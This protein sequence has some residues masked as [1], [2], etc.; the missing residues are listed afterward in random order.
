MCLW[1]DSDNKHRYPRASKLVPLAI[2]HIY[3][4]IRLYGL[5]LIREKERIY[6]KEMK[7]VL[8][9]GLLERDLFLALMNENNPKNIRSIIEVVFT[10][11]EKKRRKELLYKRFKFVH[12]FF[13]TNLEIKD[14]YAKGHNLIDYTVLFVLYN[15]Y[16]QGEYMPPQK[17][18]IAAK[19]FGLEKEQICATKESSQVEREVQTKSK[20]LALKKLANS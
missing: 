14:G 17:A 8:Q 18:Q 4:N 5:S 6:V 10:K 3:W 20:A 19:L 15:R 16:L 1:I 12:F 13:I 11:M 9:P 2:K 7:K